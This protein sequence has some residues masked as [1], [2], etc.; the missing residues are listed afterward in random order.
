M[1]ECRHDWRIVWYS[2]IN[3]PVTTHKVLE[4]MRCQVHHEV[5]P[6]IAELRAELRV[7]QGRARNHHLEAC[8]SCA[9]EESDNIFLRAENAALQNENA[10]LIQ[11]LVKV[12]ENEFKAVR[13]LRARVRELES[14]L[15]RTGWG[16]KP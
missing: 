8:E 11:T 1:E 14:S 13:E 5:L 12:Q 16:K 6:Y 10:E 7:A 15:K 2:D 4:C 9:V 3:N